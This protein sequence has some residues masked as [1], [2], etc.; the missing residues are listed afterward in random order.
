MIIAFIVLYILCWIY[1]IY[2]II[3][4]PTDVKLWGREVD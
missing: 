2:S 3:N 1:M 4:A